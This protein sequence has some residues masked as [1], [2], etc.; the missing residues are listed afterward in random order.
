MTF[1]TDF[2]KLNYAVFIE[3]YL[4]KHNAF[5]FPNFRAFKRKLMKSTKKNVSLGIQ[6][7]GQNEKG[8]HQ[9]CDTGDIQEKMKKVDMKTSSPTSLLAKNSIMLPTG[10]IRPERVKAKTE[11]MPSSGSATGKNVRFFLQILI[12]PINQNGRNI[13]F[14]SHSAE[15]SV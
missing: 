14:F 2:Y 5:I 4:T 8:K 7:R 13:I 3:I 12:L 6:P 9:S 1:V 10:V 15:K 11:T